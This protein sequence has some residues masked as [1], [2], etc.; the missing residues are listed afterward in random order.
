MDAKELTKAYHTQEARISE[1]EKQVRF[2]TD[3]YEKLRLFVDDL[4]IDVKMLNHGR[5][6]KWR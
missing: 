1:L 5:Q 6:G 2:I 3:E 4:Q